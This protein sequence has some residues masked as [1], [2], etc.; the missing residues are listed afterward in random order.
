MKPDFQT[1][2][3]LRC[4]KSG[5]RHE[6]HFNGQ[7]SGNWFIAP[8][9]STVFNPT[10]CS[11]PSSSCPG[12]ITFSCG[13]SVKWSVKQVFYYRGG[14]LCGYIHLRCQCKLI[15]TYIRYLASAEVRSFCWV[16]FCRIILEPSYIGKLLVESLET[17]RVSFFAL[18]QTTK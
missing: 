11:H 1:V 3:L 2:N 13:K 6:G 18:L 5:S 17:F 9:Q 10:S 14:F 12:A 8:L 16:H 7:L 15:V 4:F